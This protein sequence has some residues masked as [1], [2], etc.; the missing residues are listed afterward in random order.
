MFMVQDIQLQLVAIVH[1]LREND[2]MDMLLEEKTTYTLSFEINKDI[3]LRTFL[4]D[5]IFKE[6]ILTAVQIE[7]DPCQCVC[8]L[9]KIK[10]DR[11]V[12]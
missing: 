9:H 7:T 11:K 1:F 5:D 6:L 4:H 3:S 10:E 12:L 2:L 8:L